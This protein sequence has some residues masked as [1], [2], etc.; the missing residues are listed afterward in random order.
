M[1][2]SSCLAM[3][4]DAQLPRT[5]TTHYLMR[6]ISRALSLSQTLSPIT[7]YRTPSLSESIHTAQE[8][9]N[10][11]MGRDIPRFSFTLC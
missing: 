10:L 11:G 8:E 5:M 3:Q 7:P 6:S 1:L 9:G 4:H 2:M